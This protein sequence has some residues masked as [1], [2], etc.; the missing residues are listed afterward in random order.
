MG[1]DF[2]GRKVVHQSRALH[3]GW[4]IFYI[5]VGKWLSTRVISASQR[6]GPNISV[7]LLNN[8]RLN[9]ETLILV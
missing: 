4:R 8:I 6:R 7:Q 1:E 5:L 3:V 9:E 2:G